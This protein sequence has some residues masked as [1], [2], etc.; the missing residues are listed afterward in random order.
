MDAVSGMLKTTTE[1]GDL[2]QLPTRHA[3]IPS[4][5]S[6]FSSRG[7]PSIDS[8]RGGPSRP[9]ARPPHPRHDARRI[10][11]PMPPNSGL[12]RQSTLRSNISS[13]GIPYRSRGYMVPY[14]AHGRN[15]SLS[16][17]GLYGRLPFRS[18]QG[19]SDIRP[20][21]P[22]FSEACSVP[23]RMYHRGSHRAASVDAGASVHASMPYFDYQA[24]G[25]GRRNMS[26][27]CLGR[28]PSQPNLSTHPD[29]RGSPYPS[30]TTTPA[31]ASAH[32][33]RGRS[34]DHAEPLRDVQRLNSRPPKPEYYD[35]S[36]AFADPYQVPMPRVRKTRRPNV[37]TATM[38]QVPV[39]AGLQTSVS[40][41]QDT[42]TTSTEEREPGTDA[43]SEP[44][45]LTC[46]FKQPAADSG[47]ERSTNVVDDTVEEGKVS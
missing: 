17:S 21:S 11:H 16:T 15:M 35:Y 10:P 3:R 26:A 43:S 40:S 7:R 4:S 27:G 44:S 13:R 29:L 37:D 34:H 12:T 20:A 19:T 14:G 32:E 42:L 9:F 33:L 39:Q 36:E 23:S 24:Y 47:K 30:R 25:H 2:G 18:H 6:G 28:L 46:S 22:A 41:K 45:N 31:S 8:S 5:G 38:I 1:L